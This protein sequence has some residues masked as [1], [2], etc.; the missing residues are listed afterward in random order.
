[1]S[2]KDNQWEESNSKDHIS[3]SDPKSNPT[4]LPPT[5]STRCLR[6]K[7][8]LPADDSQLQKSDAPTSSGKTFFLPTMRE[9]TFIDNFCTL[10]PQGYPLLPNGNTVFV[11]LANEEV[12]NFGQVGFPKRTA[13]EYQSNGV[14]KI[15]WITCLGAITCDQLNCQWVGS[16]P[17]GNKDISK[18]LVKYLQEDV[19]EL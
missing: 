17:T 14:W 15:V 5:L 7:P 19:R 11:K 3:E 4:P 18:Y 8:K 13:V 1:M 6:G 2:S 12:T 10:D 16:P 9:E